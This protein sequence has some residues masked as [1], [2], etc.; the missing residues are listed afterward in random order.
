MGQR[1]GLGNSLE[2]QNESNKIREEE[3]GE[4]SVGRGQGKESCNIFSG[5]PNH[6]YTAV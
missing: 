6:L 4:Q 5:S 3:E 2:G 1:R